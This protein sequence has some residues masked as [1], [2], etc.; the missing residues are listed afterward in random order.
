LP[1]TTLAGKVK[2]T[3]TYEIGL[4]ENIY[5][6][7]QVDDA[8]PKKLTDFLGAG[9]TYNRFTSFKQIDNFITENRVF[10]KLCYATAKSVECY[11]GQKSTSTIS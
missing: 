5:P 2:I 11:S 10:G 8:K 7:S 9:K 1:V 4:S 3:V 6:K